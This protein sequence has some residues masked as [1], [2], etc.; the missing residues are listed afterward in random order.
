MASART[1]AEVTWTVAALKS[2]K[3]AFVAQTLEPA[4]QPPQ[5]VKMVS[6]V[7]TGHAA[8]AA[9][10]TRTAQTAMTTV[11]KTRPADLDGSPSPS[12]WKTQTVPLEAFAATAHA[13][14]HVQMEPT[15]SASQPTQVLAVAQAI[16]VS[17]RT[18]NAD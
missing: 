13:A 2:A 7:L 17:Q 16:S 9:K 11:P 10:Q 18:Q 15:L 8:A 5:H 12:A 3:T 1:T 6:T 14:R 4:A